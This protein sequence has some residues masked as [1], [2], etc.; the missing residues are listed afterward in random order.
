MWVILTLVVVVVHF[1]K[2]DWHCDLFALKKNIL[3][4]IFLIVST[5]NNYSF[6]V[7]HFSTYA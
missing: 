4:N 3:K 1:L 7:M 6:L 2:T 5:C